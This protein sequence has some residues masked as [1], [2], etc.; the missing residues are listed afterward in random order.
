MNTLRVLS[1]SK[2]VQITVTA[3]TISFGAI[4][5]MQLSGSSA[6]GTVPQTIVLFG[7]LLTTMPAS[8]FMGWIGR[9]PVFVLGALLGAAG[10][11]CAMLAIYINNFALLCAGCGL[12][13]V[14]Q[15]ISQYYRFAATEGVV[16]SEAPRAVA[17]IFAAGLIAAIIGP[18]IGI[19]VQPWFVPF[20]IA[21]P[22]AAVTVMLLLNAVGF[23]VWSDAPI[24]PGIKGGRRVREI[25]C[26]FNFIKAAL[27]G[28]GCQAIMSYVMT[29]TPLAVV[30][31]GLSPTNAAEV[32]QWH[33]VAMYAP[34][35]V[36]KYTQLG[37]RPGLTVTIGCC[38]LVG[39][40]IV[41]AAGASLVNFL[42][43]LILL[44]I[45]WNFAYVGATTLLVTGLPATD[46]VTAQGSA[47][48]MD[49]VASTAFA[50]TAGI[51]Y[52]VLG[53]SF[54]LLTALVPLAVIVSVAVVGSQRLFAGPTRF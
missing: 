30:G 50:A 45:G 42:L 39:C 12:V 21:G 37:K 24:P 15:A 8:L 41:L 33:L 19:Y 48:L 29:A 3:I 25:V 27:L 51:V 2:G 26:D 52:S 34:A 6:F 44:G 32:I 47:E 5:G 40:L 35:Y 22:W 54:V 11:A 13:G 20:A 38:S 46:Q 23:A 17:H 28:S 43:G 4:A 49:R 53:W 18:L 31:C 10:A 9:K 1:W 7:S 14:Y 16:R 36:L